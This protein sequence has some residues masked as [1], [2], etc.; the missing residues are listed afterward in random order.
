[1]FLVA[2]LRAQT[3]AVEEVTHWETA[4]CNYPRSLQ[5]VRFP[6]TASGSLAAWPATGSSLSQLHRLRYIWQNERKIRSL[7]QQEMSHSYVIALTAVIGSVSSV[8]G[9]SSAIA[10]PCSPMP[11][12]TAEAVFPPPLIHAVQ[13]NDYS[14]GMI[15]GIQSADPL[16]AFFLAWIG[17][18]R[19]M[20]TT[21]AISNLYASSVSGFSASSGPWKMPWPVQDG[22]ELVDEGGFDV[23][24]YSSSSRVGGSGVALV[25]AV[26]CSGDGA[27][28]CVASYPL[29]VPGT[30][31]R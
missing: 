23:G 30:R 5:S 3:A 25:Y 6:R 20:N 2:S 14:V 31:R 26:G 8:S 16:D 9:D 10:V 22:V 17:G 28:G 24:C 11:N 15:C 4:T 21:Y 1:V 19:T 12:S 7:R 13:W 18:P 27:C 29:E